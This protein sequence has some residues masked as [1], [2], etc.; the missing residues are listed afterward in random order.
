MNICVIGCGAVGTTIARAVEAVPDIDVV[1]LTDRSKECATRLQEKMTKVRY[2]PDIVP[3][4]TD[5]ALVVEAASQEAARY[6]LPLALSAGVDILVMSVGVFQDDEFQTD[7]FRL[8][9][10]K[11]ARVYMPSGAIGGVDALSAASLEDIQEVT[12]TTTKPPSAFE[13]NPYLESK[14]I[15]ASSLRERTEVFFGTAREAVKHFPQN[16]NVAATISLA[17][18]GFERTKIRIVCDPQ[19]ATNEHH[20]KAKGTFGELDVVTRNVP[21]PRNPKTSFL[22]ALSAISAIKKITGVVWV[23]V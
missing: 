3:I 6:Y 22:A 11:G 18:I 21:S 15:A 1:Y 9:K 7:A 5:I 4:L 12:L 13:M 8:A 16:I 23:G 2:V 20:L 10:R 14:G 17:G 19:V